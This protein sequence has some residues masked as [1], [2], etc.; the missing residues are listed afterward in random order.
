M[1]WLMLFYVMV[2]DKPQRQM[3]LPLFFQSGVIAILLCISKNIYQLSSDTLKWLS[4]LPLGNN[5]CHLQML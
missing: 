5:I 3:L 4:H 2:D 1:S